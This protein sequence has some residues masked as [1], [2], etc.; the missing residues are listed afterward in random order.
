VVLDDVTSRVEP[1]I[2]KLDGSEAGSAVVRGSVIDPAILTNLDPDTLPVTLMG[3]GVPTDLIDRETLVDG[4][5]VDSEMPRNLPRLRICALHIL[6]VRARIGAGI[7]IIGIMDGNL[8]GMQWSSRP[9]AI[10]AR[11]E[12][13][14]DI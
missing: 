3:A 5:V 6:G 14:D 7:V 2:V 11:D 8:R 13:N 9:V 12:I 1:E 10:G 4:V